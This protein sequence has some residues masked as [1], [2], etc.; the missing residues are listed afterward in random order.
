MKAN[1]YHT[2]RDQAFKTWQQVFDV[3]YFWPVDRTE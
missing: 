1:A 2:V 3:N